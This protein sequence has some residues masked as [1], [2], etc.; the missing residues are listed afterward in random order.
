MPLTH[1]S[2]TH[3][4][5]VKEHARILLLVWTWEEGFTFDDKH[6]LG[7]CRGKFTMQ[8]LCE[9]RGNEAIGEFAVCITSGVYEVPFL[10]HLGEV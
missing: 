7:L 1:A 10:F 4:H 6:S 8:V 2:Q 3:A 5:L 9:R